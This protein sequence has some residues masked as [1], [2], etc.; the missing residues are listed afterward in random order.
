[1][2]KNRNQF[3]KFGR[4]EG[5]E[6]TIAAIRALPLGFNLSDGIPSR[7]LESVYIESVVIEVG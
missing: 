3:T 7:P 4:L 2:P 6:D 1:M 5:S